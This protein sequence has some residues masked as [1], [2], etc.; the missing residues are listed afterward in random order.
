[1]PRILPSAGRC[2][3]LSGARFLFLVTGVDTK[4]VVALACLVEVT[5]INDEARLIRNV[6]SLS[7]CVRMSTYRSRLYN[8]KW[9]I[10]GTWCT[11]I[12]FASESTDGILTNR[13]VVRFC[14][15]DHKYAV[16][17]RVPFPFI[18]KKVAMVEIR[19][20]SL[21]NESNHG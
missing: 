19:T 1:M 10:P 5:P 20:G 21:P 7:T 16:H 2:P 12:F 13:S 4:R 17:G 9:Y 11:F 6:F 3:V 8:R 14:W 18:H 15:Q